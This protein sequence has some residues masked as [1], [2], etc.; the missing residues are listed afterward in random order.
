MAKTDKIQKVTKTNYDGYITIDYTSGK[1]ES[2]EGMNL[3][4]QKIQ[5]QIAKHNI[6]TENCF[7][8]EL[9]T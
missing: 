4:P 1:R 7:W 9:Q 8:Y 3:I 6:E 2:Y 5:Q